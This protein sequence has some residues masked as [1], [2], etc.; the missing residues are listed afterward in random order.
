MYRGI[1]AC[2][3]LRRMVLH[4]SCDRGDIYYVL[5]CECSALL[6]NVVASARALPA[7]RARLVGYTGIY[8]LMSAS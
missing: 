8:K 6:D 4:K 3:G 2:A 5:T 1:P 7:L